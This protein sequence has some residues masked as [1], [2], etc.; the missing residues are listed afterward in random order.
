[1]G[2]SRAE[3]QAY[4]ASQGI[5]P[6]SSTYSGTGAVDVLQAQRPNPNLGYLQVG[7]QALPRLFPGEKTPQEELQAA[8]AES[9][10]AQAA[11]LQGNKPGGSSSITPASGA[12]GGGLG[13]GGLGSML[14][15]WLGGSSTAAAPATAAAT[16]TAAVPT[17]AAGAGA[18]TA[19]AAGAGAGAAG[20]T[21]GGMAGIGSTIGAYALPAAGLGAAG[22]GA[23]KLSNRNK[24]DDANEWEYAT[25]NGAITG[26]GIGT[27]ILPGV[28]TAIGGALGGAAG[29]A[30]AQLGGHKG[31][32]QQRRDGYRKIMKN[33]GAL[34][35]EYN[36]T[37]SDGTKFNF[38]LD[39]SKANYNVDF[40]R[41]GIGDV[42]GGLNPLAAII[43][44][45]GGKNGKQ[46]S[47]LAGQY[48][49]F[50]T[51]GGDIGANIRKAYTDAGLDHDTA[52]GLIHEMQQSGKISQGEGD[53]YKNGLDQAFGVGA[54]AKNKGVSP[55][56]VGASTQSNKNTTINDLVARQGSQQTIKQPTVATV[57]GA[58][59]NL[60]QLNAAMRRY[61]K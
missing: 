22:Y 3:A 59:Q 24:W 15:S 2:M 27:M 9:I 37:T 34:D 7:A 61:W 33:T 10:R 46:R 42:V 40:S 57:G 32:D 35:N 36:A 11:A 12:T 19:G 45:G 28:G 26:A 20:S 55:Y 48:T 6:P 49:N 51:S 21:A 5:Y 43:T 29:F 4:L 13:L 25:R 38:G 41:D 31:R 1:M 14:P 54:Y 44:Q 23:Y 47:D 39:G 18:G 60:E 8:M 53:A 50:A 56:K 58:R 17:A 16:T 52:Y 30:A